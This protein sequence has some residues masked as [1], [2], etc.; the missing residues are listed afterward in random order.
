MSDTLT[1]FASWSCSYSCLG[2]TDLPLRNAGFLH[3]YLL[4]LRY[5]ALATFDSCWM[6]WVSFSVLLVLLSHI[7]PYVFANLPLLQSEGEYSRSL[8]FIHVCTNFKS[9]STSSEWGIRKVPCPSYRLSSL[10]IHYLNPHI[11]C[12]A[13]LVL[14]FAEQLFYDPGVVIYCCVSACPPWAWPKGCTVYFRSMILMSSFVIG[15]G[16]GFSTSSL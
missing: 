10:A 3:L 1:L 9:F 14:G 12:P 2:H 11:S 4:S 6:A 15:V 5:P 7:I 8:R 16:I 13:A